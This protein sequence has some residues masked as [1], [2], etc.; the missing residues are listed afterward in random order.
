MGCKRKLV[1][2]VYPFIP[3]FICSLH[4]S[5]PASVLLTKSGAG[6]EEDSRGAS[7]YPF[8]GNNLSECIFEAISNVSSSPSHVPSGLMQTCA[9][10]LISLSPQEKGETEVLDNPQSHHWQRRVGHWPLH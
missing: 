4:L 6:Q 2:L 3:S 10:S 5:S 7:I 9:F 1:F 8:L